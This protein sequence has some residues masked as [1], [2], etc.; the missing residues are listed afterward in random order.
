VIDLRPVAEQEDAKVSA[1]YQVDNAG[2][3]KELDLVFATGSPRLDVTDFKVTLDGAPVT[4]QADDVKLPESWQGPKETPLF[5]GSTLNYR[6]RGSGARGFHVSLPPGA[7][8]LVVTYSAEAATYHMKQPVIVHQ[9]GYVL[10]PART[11]KSFGGLDVTVHVPAGW[12][13][14][15]TP[16]LARKGD[17]LTGT[18]PSIPA[19]AIA[20]TLR[21]PLGL[22]PVIDTIAMVLFGIVLIGGP[23]VCWRKGK[24]RWALLWSVLYLA[25]GVATMELAPS[26]LPPG[27]WDH[28]G[29]GIGLALL[30]LSSPIVLVVGAIIATVGRRVQVKKLES[31]TV[32]SDMRL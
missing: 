3:V 25:A 11:W 8:T 16:A 23:V 12:Q 14:A 7:H 30:I 22:Y 2:D 32:P 24:K 27:Q 15:I 13:I 4:Q 17:T 10:S 26:F 28:R 29:Y 18:F 9:F 31:G 20:L 5:D 6:Q 21:A 19:D 1:T